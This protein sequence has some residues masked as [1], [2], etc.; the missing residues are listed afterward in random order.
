[1]ALLI[2]MKSRTSPTPASVR[3][4][5]HEDGSVWIVEL[6][7]REGVGR[8]LDPK[9]PPRSWSSSAAEDAGRIEPWGAEPIDGAVSRD[10]CRR[11]QVSDQAVIGDQWVVGH[12]SS[13]RNV[14]MRPCSA[15][16]GL[17]NLTR[18]G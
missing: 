6:L 15:N 4:S 18:T 8:R 14:G 17:A 10:Q 13:I 12:Q 5:S 16:S 9:W 11:L 3:K 7:S 1:M 2:G